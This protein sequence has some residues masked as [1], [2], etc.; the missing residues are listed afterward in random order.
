MKKIFTPLFVFLLCSGFSSYAQSDSVHY[1]GYM[2][3]YKISTPSFPVNEVVVFWR[4]SV[5]AFN[6]DGKQGAFTHVEGD[7]FSFHVDD[8]S[9]TVTFRENKRTKGSDIVIV[10]DGETYVGTKKP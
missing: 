5:L 9:G 6:A 7:Q 3:T 8:H 10:M 4:D 2:G 1:K